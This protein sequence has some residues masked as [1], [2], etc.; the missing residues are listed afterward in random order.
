MKLP[1]CYGCHVPYTRATLRFMTLSIRLLSR[2]F[3]T[4]G[5]RYSPFSYTMPP[6]TSRHLV[7]PSSMGSFPF[8]PGTPSAAPE[9]VS[10]GA[11]F[12]AWSCFPIGNLEVRVCIIFVA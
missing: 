7:Q 1:S 11:S 5:F 2:L 10:G 9:G 8:L 6:L 4:Q 12:S 3:S